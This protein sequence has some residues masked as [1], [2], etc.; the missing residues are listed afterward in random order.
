MDKFTILK[1]YFGYDQFRYPQDIIIDAVYQNKEVI[2][3]LPTGFGKSIIFQVLALMLD[4]VTIVI[5]PLIAL[6][7][8]Q[9]QTL[10]R[11]GI[12]ATLL[13]SN[14]SFEDQQ[15]VYH[16]LASKKYKLLYLSPERLENLYFLKQIVKEQISMIVVDEAHTLLWA[17]SFRKA[18]GHISGFIH[19]LKNRP[20]IL[21]V[22][23]TATPLT[24][25]KISAVLELQN[26]FVVKTSVDRPNIKYIV[27]QPKSKLNFILNYIAKHFKE[28]GIIYC[29]TRKKVEELHH[30]LTVYQISNTYY[31]GGLV[32]ELKQK[33]QE[34]FTKDE[35]LLM[36]CTNA[37]GMGIDIPNI[38]FVIEYETPQSIE[39]LVQQIGRVS[40]DGAYGEGI[41]LFSFSDLDTNQFFIEQMEDSKARKQAILKLDAVV[42]YCL[43]NRCRHN[44]I[45]KYFKETLKPCKSYCDICDK[46]NR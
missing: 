37:F 24:I 46:R 2:G 13:N 30:I 1:E 39:D 33:N 40:R 25:H 12:P 28:K 31:H 18:F 26:P 41:V 4:G 45:A 35:A 8:D 21:A 6:M 22:T 27:E 16:R 20:K 36:V 32:P 29:M 9:V 44:F 23:A 3:I 17:D 7:E 11:E 43:G 15:K 10:K 38:R 42:D 14:M 34:A 5:S 19:T